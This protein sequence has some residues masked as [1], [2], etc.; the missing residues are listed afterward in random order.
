MTNE[1]PQPPRNPPSYLKYLCGLPQDASRKEFEDA[2]RAQVEPLVAIGPKFLYDNEVRRL[3][4]AGVPATKAE[5]IFLQTSRGQMLRN[6]IDREGKARARAAAQ[7]PP[8][9]AANCNNPLPVVRS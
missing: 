4:A 5:R 6:A 9:A 2:W 1:P 3:M 7:K 8:F